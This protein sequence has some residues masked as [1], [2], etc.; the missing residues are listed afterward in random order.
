MSGAQRFSIGDYAW[1]VGEFLQRRYQV[2]DFSHATPESRHLL[3][4][5]DVDMCLR[6]AVRLAEVEAELGVS[7]SYF[8]LVN[9]EMYN[10][11]SNAGR[12]SLRRLL[13]L[14]HEVGLHFDAAHVRENDLDTLTRE[15]DRES[16]ILEMQM[17]HPVRVVTFHRPARW[18]IGH[19]ASL[20][21]RIHGY[22]PRYFEHMG[23]CSDSAGAFRYHAPLDHPAVQEGRALQLLTHPIWWVAEPDEGTFAKLARFR[24]DRDD[25]MGRELAVHCRPYAEGLAAEAVDIPLSASPTRP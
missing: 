22:Q 11:G 1:L 3:L 14:G 16:S 25:E 2:V 18:L 21:G 8:I 12:Q 10:I 17:G 24:R 6:R 7:A 20:S 4:R 19:A 15:V 13:D 9:T 23:Y 5:H